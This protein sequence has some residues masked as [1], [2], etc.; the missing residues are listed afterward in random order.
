MHF[1]TVLAY[2]KSKFSPSANHGGRDFFTLKLAEL[3]SHIFVL[4]RIQVQTSEI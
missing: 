4:G 1:K 3:T 2:L